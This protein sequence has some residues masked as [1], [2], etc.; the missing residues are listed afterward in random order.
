MR[1]RAAAA[2]GAMEGEI[3]KA[4]AGKDQVVHQLL[5]TFLAGGHLLLTD[6]PGVGKTTLALAFS[7]AAS[8]TFRRVQCTPDL[9]P[10][11]ITGFTVYRK[12]QDRFIY[13]PGAAMTQ[14]L[15]A[16]EINRTSS[17]TQSA[18]LEVM[19]EGTVTV[20]GE[21][22]PVPAPFFVIATE[23]PAGAYGTQR[24]PEA[25]LD[26]FMMELTVGYPD[27]TAEIQLLKDRR[28]R[29]PLTEVQAQAGP[30]AL[31]AMRK[32]VRE[33]YVHDRIYSYLAD[34]VRATREEAALARGLSPRAGLQILAAA[35]AEAFLAGRDYVVPADVDGV[36]IACGRH[37]V[38]MAGR[39]L[40]EGQ[41]PDQV[42]AAVLEN[43]RKAARWDGGAEAR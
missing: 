10:S 1:R 24:L 14:V 25:E 43:V 39:A 33:V 42:L 26:R 21:T 5:V 7:R 3:R 13:Q 18:L 28:D 34:L 15:L 27:R 36:F 32:L 38:Q 35:Q 6:I 11:D 41:G 17:R 12:D 20:D 2:A 19:Q 40:T 9:M 4:V 8:L 37:R 22:R 29:D 16:D 31:L 23:N 30:D